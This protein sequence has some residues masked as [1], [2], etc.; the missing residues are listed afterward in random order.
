MENMKYTL[1][2][3]LHDKVEPR[4]IHSPIWANTEKKKE[5]C[6][7][8]Q[9]STDTVILV[10]VGP[11]YEVFHQDA[12]VLTE[13]SPMPYMKGIVAHTGFPAKV[14]SEY[15]DLLNENGHKNVRII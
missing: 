12:D 4:S 9:E 6:R 7:I 11:F 2:N 15:I 3:H 14:L 13:I 5:W 10:K 8:K 1:G